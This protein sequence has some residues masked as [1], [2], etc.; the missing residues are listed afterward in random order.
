MTVCTYQS[1]C[2][3]LKLHLTQFVQLREKREKLVVYILH[4]WVN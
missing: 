4:Q 3:T 2:F 1:P